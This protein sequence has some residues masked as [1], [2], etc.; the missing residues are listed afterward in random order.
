MDSLP[1]GLPQHYPPPGTVAGE[2]RAEIRAKQMALRDI[3]LRGGGPVTAP[4]VD[5][6]CV[7]VVGMHR[8]GTS[9]TTGLLA[10]LGLTGPRPDDVFPTDQTNE[11]GHWESVSVYEC[12]ERLLRATGSSRYVPPPITL[13][14]DDVAGYDEIRRAALDWFATNYVGRP[15]VVKDPRFCLTLPFWREVLPAPMAAVFVLRNP[16]SVVRSMQ[17]R[18]DFPVTFS[19]AIWD[20]YVRSASRVLEGVPT[21][22]V[23]Y[24]AMMADGTAA[25]EEI[26]RFLRQVG[27]PIESARSDA[28]ARFLDAGLHHQHAEHDEYEDIAL[29]QRQMFEVISD[30]RGAHQSWTPPPLP[31]EPFWVDDVLTLRRHSLHENRR[32][33]SELKKLRSTR[34][35]RTSAALKRIGARAHAKYLGRT[36]VSSASNR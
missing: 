11:R 9:A 16:L 7:A 2:R 10:T 20:R 14:W 26:G 21:L 29:S 25:T 28:A 5:N 15:M 27:V 18:D 32:L 13:Q 19:L 23:E 1:S 35:R 12:N 4:R 8:S 3:A 6:W 36:A 24:D 31:Q 33:R 17:A 22:V 34:I 30:L